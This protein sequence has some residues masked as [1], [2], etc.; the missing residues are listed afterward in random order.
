M[1]VYLSDWAADALEPEWL[2]DFT[3]ESFGAC[4]AAAAEALRPVPFRHTGKDCIVRC[5]SAC[6]CKHKLR[7]SHVSHA[8]MLQVGPSVSKLQNRTLAALLLGPRPLP[9]S[10]SPLPAHQKTPLGMAA[11]WLHACLLSLPTFTAKPEHALTAHAA[12]CHWLYGK[13]FRCS[14]EVSGR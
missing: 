6:A 4:V 10:Y 1:H 5:V 2:R 3:F 11:V 8:C 9:G 14:L 7:L 12:G 13:T